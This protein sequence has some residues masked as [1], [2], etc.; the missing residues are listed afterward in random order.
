MLPLFSTPPAPAPTSSP[1]PPAAPATTGPTHTAADAAMEA[2]LSHWFSA[3]HFDWMALH[4]INAVRLPLGWW[5]VLEPPELPDAG[6]GKAWARMA[7]GPTPG[8]AAIGRVLDWAAERQMSVLLDLHG[9]PG[10]QNGKDHSGCAGVAEWHLFSVNNS[11][12]V[13]RRLMERFGNHDALWGIELLNEP[14]DLYTAPT[15]DAMRPELLRYY[16]EAYDIV[17]AHR[18]D[19]VLVFCVLYWFDFWAWASELREPRF[20]N[21]ALDVHMYTAFDGF[22]AATAEDKIVQ[23]A[24]GFGCRI[25][26]HQSHHP[27][28]VGE[29]ALAVDPGGAR[30]T[31]AF[32]DAQ[33]LAFSSAL[34]SYFWTF[35]MDA[36]AEMAERGEGGTKIGPSPQWDFTK[37]MDATP[38]IQ[39]DGQ[40]ST[41]LFPDLAKHFTGA[42][43]AP[44]L[45]QIL[46]SR[47]RSLPRQPPP[48]LS[49]HHLPRASDE[50]AC[51]ACPYVSPTGLVLLSGAILVSCVVCCLCCVRTSRRR[52]R[53]SQRRHTRAVQMAMAARNPLAAPLI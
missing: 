36:D 19:V 53:Q 35:K 4:G 14:G 5:D 27:M 12:A 43:D 2:H 20:Y 39:P 37:A 21:V 9:G 13:V 34:G 30:V 17:R 10:G 1:A 32:V 11:L 45:A 15:E 24:R 41:Y 46:S 49:L 47:V 3:A 52:R 7:P 26:Q 25:L 16:E 22:T 42:P 50:D 38:N 44:T 48:P 6:S 28:V 8:L 40:P 31:Q 51:P 33:M 23:A 29:W 18:V